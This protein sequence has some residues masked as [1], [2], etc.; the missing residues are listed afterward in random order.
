MSENRQIHDD[1]GVSESALHEEMSAWRK[2]T[3]RKLLLVFAVINA[4]VTT[5]QFF[6][7]SYTP[8]V[9]ETVLVIAF[10]IMLFLLAL[11][12]HIPYAVKGAFL[13]LMVYS[14]I[15]KQ[16]WMHGLVSTAPISLVVMPLM[17]FL[18]FSPRIGWGTGIV[19]AV[20][21]IGFTIAYQN[22]RASALI[23]IGTD[24][25]DAS[26]WLEVGLSLFGM[27][28][29]VLVIMNQYH[30][31]VLNAVQSE[32]VQFQKT[33]AAQTAT[34]FAMAKLAEFR[35]TDTG[36]HLERVREYS[37]I[38]AQSLRNEPKYR[39]CIDTEFL[40]DI[41]HA[42]ALHDIGKVAISDAILR[43]PARLT[44]AEF[45]VMKSHTTVGAEKLQLVY[46]SYP[47]NHFIR[48]GI[49]IALTHHEWWNGAGYPKGLRGEEIPLEGRIMALAD[50]YDALTSERPYKP[51]FSHAKSRDILVAQQGHQFDPD[52]IK[53][54]LES[55]D[56]FYAI[57]QRYQNQ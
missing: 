10:C 24:P 35:D 15:A 23:H 30:R 12:P 19:S 42:S 38:I 9:W 5:L 40:E 45:D 52:V 1:S 20:M 11:L 21:F 17:A 31:L 7:I 2:A 32:K 44:D 47:D 53:A 29:A 56:Q 33:T 18:L 16:L 14:G 57:S 3:L 27:L 37:K 48:M 22:R 49:D 51:P 4:V 43:K 41:Y 26:V 8:G 46:K 39:H 13:I 55:Q 25:A 28:A 50:A 54:F 6:V 36:G 34:I